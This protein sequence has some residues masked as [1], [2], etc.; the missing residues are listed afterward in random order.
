MNKDLFLEALSAWKKVLGEGNVTTSADTISA[1]ETATFKTEQ[2]VRALLSP[3]NREELQACLRIANQFQI[4]VYPISRGKNWGYGSKVPT[5]HNCAVIDLSH[6]SRILEFDED[7]AYVTIEPGVTQRQ[8]DRFLKDKKS[9]LWMSPTTGS[10]D[11]SL[12]GITLERG[13]GRTPYGEYANQTCAYEV[14]LPNGD[15]VHTGQ[16]RFSDSKTANLEKW[17]SGPSLDGLFQQSSFGIVTKMTLW[18]MP[19]PESFKVIYAAVHD[20]QT[21]GQVSEVLRALRLDGTIPNVQVA[22]EYRFL[23][24]SSLYPWARTGGTTPLKPDL[25]LSLIKEQGFALWNIVIPVYGYRDTVDVSINRVREKLESLGLEL[26]VIDKPIENATD[27]LSRLHRLWGADLENASALKRAYWRMRKSPE[28][29][30]DMDLDRDGCGVIFVGLSVPFRG[31]DIL[32][33][34]ELIRRLFLK[35][36]Y[37]PDLNFVALRERFLNFQCILCYDRTIPGEDEKAMACYKDVTQELMNAG[38]YSARLGVQ[39]MSA[40][41]RE[42][43]GTTTFLRLLKDTIDPNGIMSP[44][45][46]S[47]VKK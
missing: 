5:G 45:R 25:A 39:G 47:K 17:G 43:A 18:L 33:A 27:L 10:P 23:A 24:R 2:K 31:K 41:N 38:F 28:K 1:I 22:N 14:V 20:N 32:A 29:T 26:K 7:L 19:A 44:G 13:Y 34:N 36:G 46:Y 8:L 9:K 12:V 6:M 37:E 30:T 11:G 35:H 21:M 4:G 3:S 16:S 15:C 42:D 40:L